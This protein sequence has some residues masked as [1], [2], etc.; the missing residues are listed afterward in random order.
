MTEDD[1]DQ[2]IRSQRPRPGWATSHS[3]AAVL[4]RVLKTAAGPA[5]ARGRRVTPIRVLAAAA[6]AA[7][8]VAGA[9]VGARELRSGDDLSARPTNGTT[10][11]IQQGYAYDVISLPVVMAN[12]DTVF[13]GKVVGIA[14]RD[15]S[16]GWTTYRVQLLRTVKG[17][18]PDEVQTRQRGYIDENGTSHIGDRQPLVEIGKIYMFATNHE[19]AQ[20]VYTVAPGLHG[21]RQ[22]AND[23]Q[24]A[25]LATQ[26]AKAAR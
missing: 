21:A 3:G 2:R 16:D 23:R 7:V 15:E 19:S 17:T 24:I 8:V 22:A 14:A 10:E 20:N 5:A 18:P 13:A 26:Y 6:A 4:D 9:V 12:T 25:E 1:L 11:T